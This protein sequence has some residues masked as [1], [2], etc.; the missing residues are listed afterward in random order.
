MS[1]PVEFSPGYRSAYSAG[2][3][4]AH[5][6]DWPRLWQSYVGSYRVGVACGTITDEQ[7]SVLLCGLWHGLCDAHAGL[8]D[9]PTGAVLRHG[10]LVVTS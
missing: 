4:L 8:S 6:A 3:R 10:G 2:A 9:L 7:C 5:S 1:V